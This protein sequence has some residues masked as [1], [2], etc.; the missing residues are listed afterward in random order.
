MNEAPTS[1]V[2]LPD[3]AALPENTPLP[4][5]LRVAEFV[6]LDDALGTLAFAL[7]GPNAALFEADA[8][9]LYL[10]AG[11][12]L[13]FE[14]QSVHT[15]TVVASDPSLPGTPALSA[16]FTLF[17]TDV[18]E[19][20]TNLSLVGTTIAE[21]NEVGAVVGMF[22]AAD[23][24]VG[25]AIRFELVGGEGAAGNGA[26]VIDGSRLLAAERFNFE[27]QNRYSIRVRAT[28]AAGASTEAVFTIDVI[29][30]A[31]EPLEVEFVTLPAAG[32]YRVGQTL[33]VTV[34][35]SQAVAVRGVPTLQLRM[36]GRLHDAAYSGGSGSTVLTFKYR[37]VPGDAATGVALGRGFE[38]SR[39]AAIVADGSRVPENLPARFR[40]LSASDVIV[41]G[42]PPKIVGRVGMPR[43][44]TYRSGQTLVFTVRFSEAVVVEGVPRIRLFIGSA[45]RE[46]E[47]VGGAGSR[48]L[49]F[50]YTVP[51]VTGRRRGRPVELGQRIIGGQIMDVAGNLSLRALK[52]PQ[53]S[54]VKVV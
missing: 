8:T 23:P 34:G 3:A 33:L 28:D 2:L 35:F 48:E 20:P 42:R 38:F 26:F 6:I 41:D 39:R 27:V 40:G 1:L 18:N 25:D 43:A 45:M 37:V 46:A 36:G 52:E 11:A 4:T 30:D 44:G 12:V 22:T 13:D 15:V 21:N 47:Y 50:A 5:R 32:T 49:R 10:R 24:D 16:T 31:N 9:G 7:T 53:A 51:A 29:D 54:R 14:R 19:A 17:V